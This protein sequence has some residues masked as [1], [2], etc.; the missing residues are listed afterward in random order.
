MHYMMGSLKFVD[1]SIINLDESAA[2]QISEAIE[3]ANAWDDVTG[4]KIITLI[5]KEGRGRI[6]PMSSV[7]YIDINL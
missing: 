5:D 1:G 3:K 2:K 4:K 7:L 6:F